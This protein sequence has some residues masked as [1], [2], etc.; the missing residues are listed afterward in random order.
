MRSV[1]NNFIPERIA[2]K[3]GEKNEHLSLSGVVVPTVLADDWKFMILQSSL[4]PI[5]A[6]AWSDVLRVPKN[7]V[8]RIVWYS[9]EHTGGDGNLDY[10]VI[11]PIAADVK[12]KFVQDRYR[13]AL[14]W[15]VSSAVANGIIDDTLNAGSFVNLNSD[16]RL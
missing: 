2:F 4:G 13:D 6:D 3:T 12:S 11:A 8:L 14:T 16:I 15:G 9:I 5:G 10:M 1:E 7:V